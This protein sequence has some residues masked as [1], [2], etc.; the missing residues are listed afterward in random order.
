MVLVLHVMVR[1]LL[2]MIKLKD[3]IT[4]AQL[5]KYQIFSP[6][7]GGSTNDFKWKKVPKV[8]DIRIYNMYDARGKCINKPYGSF[9]T[10]SYKEKYKGSEWTDWKKKKH[11][12]WVSGMG[13]VFEVQSGVKILKIKSHNDY[14]KIQKKYPIKLG[15][16]GYEDD[17]NCPSGDLYVDWPSI[18]KRYDGL[19]LA[20][21]S[22]MIP[23][24]GQWDVES[25]AWFSMRKLK[26][27]GTA[28][29]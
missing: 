25:T 17:F 10:S 14:L 7:T 9:W 12:T 23:M 5:S 19:Q 24:L 20:G 21:S 13:A 29:V 16:F 27:V 22:M 1:V 11:P 8:N 15:K 3:L 18:A 28:K 26:F 6:G 4:E 2:K